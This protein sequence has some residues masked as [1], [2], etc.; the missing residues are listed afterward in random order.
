MAIVL[1]F[2][3]FFSILSLKWSS[4]SLVLYLQ[5]LGD[6]ILGLA[7]FFLSAGVPGDAKDFFTQVDALACLEN[8]RQV[9]EVF[10]ACH[11][12]KLLIC[13]GIRLLLF[14]KIDVDSYLPHNVCPST[15]R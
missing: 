9:F 4:A 10:I 2:F 12:N 7:K 5:I 1:P 13:D 8:N 15:N 14:K 11:F 3:F 6:K